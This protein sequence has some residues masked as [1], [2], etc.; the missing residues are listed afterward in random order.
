MRGLR[1]Q[2]RAAL[3]AH[4]FVGVG[5]RLLKQSVGWSGR[6]S[7]R[8]ISIGSVPFLHLFLPVPDGLQRPP[9]HMGPRGHGQLLGQHGVILVTRG[10]LSPVL[11][12]TTL[13][14]D[15]EEGRQV[16]ALFLGLEKGQK[17]IQIFLYE[18]N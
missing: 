9:G 7:M 17:N 15:G 2:P 5:L 8:F 1:L 3:Q 16:G 4:P 11:D 6:V 10:C 18:N 13:T 12:G 14:V